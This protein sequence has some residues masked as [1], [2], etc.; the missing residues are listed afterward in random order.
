MKQEHLKKDQH[1]QLNEEIMKEREKIIKYNKQYI[2]KYQKF[3]PTTFDYYK[4]VK[5]IGNGA[6]G[7]VYLAIHKLTG[8]FVAIKMI[9]L[10]QLKD[11]YSRKKVFQEV[12]IL[13]KIRHSNIIRLFEVFENKKHIMMVMEYAGGGDLYHLV[14]KSEYLTEDE[15]KYIFKQ[16]AQGVAHCHCRSVLH[17]DIKLDNI[18][19]DGDGGVKIC[20]F[21]VSKLI[22]QNEVI[23]EQCGTPAYLAPE[24]SSNSEYSNF[25]VDIWSLGI[26]LYVMLQGTVPFKA[27]SMEGLYQSQLRMNIQFPIDISPEA[28]NLIRRMLVVKPIDRISLP[29][30][31]SHPWLRHIL[32]PD[33]LPCETETEEEE[34]AHNFNMS[35]SF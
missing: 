8:K 29:E 13:K 7:Q 33:G 28:Q 23:Q 20:D 24:M 10:V 17:R 32:G 2:K 21:G 15:A 34:D 25:F 27:S 31:L 9:E 14:K 11:K 1:Q 4:F 35:L 19:L 5:K 30:L 16:I 12:Y 26:L 6:F 3:P 18:L 22:T